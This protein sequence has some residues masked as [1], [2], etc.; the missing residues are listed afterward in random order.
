MG[1]FMSRSM[2]SP[3]SPVLDDKFLDFSECK[4]FRSKHPLLKHRFYLHADDVLCLWLGHSRQ[5]DNFVA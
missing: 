2:G 4:L 1:N 3:F 5:L